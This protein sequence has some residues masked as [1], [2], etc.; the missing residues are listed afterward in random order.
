MC[1]PNLMPYDAFWPEKLNKALKYLQIIVMF[2]E[3]LDY[4][5][6]T[7]MIQ[8]NTN[9]PSSCTSQNYSHNVEN[10]LLGDKQPTSPKNA[11]KS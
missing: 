2:I 9:F 8:A 6:A 10:A 1:K 3:G 11:R 5:M 7:Y 4:N